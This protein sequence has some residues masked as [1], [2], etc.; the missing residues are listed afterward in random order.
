MNDAQ[1]MALV[2]GVVEQQCNQMM[3]ELERKMAAALAAMHDKWREESQRESLQ[4]LRQRSALTPIMRYALLPAVADT[5][6]LH[7]QFWYNPPVKKVKRR[8]PLFQLSIR[9]WTCP[10][11]EIGAYPNG[12]GQELFVPLFRPGSKGFRR[13]DG[14]LDYLP[15]TG[16]A[17]VGCVSTPKRHFDQAALMSPANNLTLYIRGEVLELGQPHMTPPD[18]KPNAAKMHWF[19]QRAS[20]PSLV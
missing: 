10:E 16:A 17:F 3:R 12:T 5:T 13:F 18:A 6:K 2:Q 7:A 11:D 14:Q 15:V 1:I 9:T 8:L 20:L 19:Y 4:E